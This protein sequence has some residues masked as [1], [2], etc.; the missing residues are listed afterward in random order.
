MARAEGRG[1][2]KSG[3]F[4]QL[5]ILTLLM[6]GGGLALMSAFLKFY[7]VPARE[8]KLTHQITDSNALV[9]LLD[10]KR[11]TKPSR[12]IWDLRARFREAS[13]NRA[14]KSLRQMVQEQLGILQFTNF[15]P[16]T[17]PR[18]PR[19]GGTVEQMQSID[20]KD[21]SLQDIFQFAARVKEE[22]P[23]VHVGMINLSRRSRSMAP[24]G[25]GGIE[26]SWTASIQF[27][28]YS[29]RPRSAGAKRM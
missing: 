25:T 23:S 9:A 6:T 27:Y 28:T 29:I 26:D 5:V 2:S 24:G 17:S 14:S 15:P 16:T 7:L 12:E 10:P 18:N 1:A 22:N 19:E 20:L 21:A 11:N 3:E 8:A 13:K 4:L